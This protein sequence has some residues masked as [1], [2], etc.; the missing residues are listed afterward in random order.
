[1][2]A[3]TLG[4][5]FWRFNWITGIARATLLKY[6]R[7]LVKKSDGNNQ[8]HRINLNKVTVIWRYRAMTY[9]A[10]KDD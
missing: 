10:Y 3:K 4:T 8:G 5:K 6:F 9:I 7:V 1:V 2:L